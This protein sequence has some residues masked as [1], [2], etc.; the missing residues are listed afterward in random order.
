MKRLRSPVFRP[1]LLALSLGLAGLP[2][3]LSAATAPAS[4]SNEAQAR[5]I[6]R[7]KAAAPSVLAKPMASRAAPAEVADLAGQRAHAL[8]LRTGLAAR[9]GL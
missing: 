3:G 7:F 5:V 2:I 1:S 6:V 8:A 4:A 9:G